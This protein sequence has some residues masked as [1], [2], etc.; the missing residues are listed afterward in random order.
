MATGRDIS[1]RY[2]RDANTERKLLTPETSSVNSVKRNQ[3]KL[4]Q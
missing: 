2:A 1:T 4:G 3:L